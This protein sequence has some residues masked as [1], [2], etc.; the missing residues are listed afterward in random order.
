MMKSEMNIEL[1][2][3]YVTGS[4]SEVEKDS[5]DKWLKEDVDHKH[6]F[7]AL[8]SYWELTGSSCD[9]YEPDMTLGWEK[10]SRETVHKKVVPFRQKSVSIQLLRIAAAVL[11]LLAGWFVSRLVIDK[12]GKPESQLFVYRS[13]D[14]LKKVQ[15]IDG[16]VVWLNNNSVISIPV[17]FNTKSRSLTLEGEAYF[18]VAKNKKLPFII[19]AGKTITKVVGTSFNIR[20]KRNENKVRVT[21]YSGTVAFYPAGNKRATQVLMQGDRGIFKSDS[22]EIWKELSHVSNDLAWK[23]GTLQFKNAPISEVCE[24]LSEYFNVKIEVSSA[25]PDTKVF[26]GNFHNASLNEILDIIALTLDIE[27]VKKDNRLVV[28]P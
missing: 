18:E 4:A 8:R 27:F 12:V 26:T 14:M 19:S 16:S 23:T 1:A 3:R 5:F 10:V 6:Q 9:N 22:K 11:L 21:V 28:K 2:V 7:E 13:T 20:A 25:I 15:L 24:I 17:G